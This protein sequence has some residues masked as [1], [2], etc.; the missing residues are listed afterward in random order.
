MTETIIRN[1][2]KDDVQACASAF[3]EV[4]GPQ[5]CG[6]L[7]TLAT[8]LKHI[9]ENTVEKELCFV[10]EVE[11]KIVGMILAMTTAREEYE[12][13]FVDTICVL[14]EYQ[15]SGIG[16]ALF[17]KIEEVAKNRGAHFVRLFGKPTLL[18]FDW[19]KRHGM[20]ESGWV[21]LEKKIA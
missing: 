16:N 20:T 5:G 21:E 13:V 9:E 10:A 8:S 17:T 3:L 1:F 12:D 2:S 7:W 6:E 19:Y 18:S 4:F 11:G 14:S 15:G